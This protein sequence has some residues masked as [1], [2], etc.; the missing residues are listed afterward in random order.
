MN[1]PF[2]GQTVTFKTNEKQRI[3][4]EVNGDN[5]QEVLPATIVAVW[6]KETVNLKVQV[7]GRSADLWVTSVQKGT[8]EYEWQPIDE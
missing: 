7:D 1:K 8:G 4:M 2:V 6:S 3:A 5:T